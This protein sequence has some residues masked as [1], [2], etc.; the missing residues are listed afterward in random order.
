L[1]A[2]I[3]QAG[4]G[5]VALPAVTGLATALPG[6]TLGPTMKNL[7]RVL[8]FFRPDRARI[9]VSL[10]L[11]LL[12]TTA[13]LL[14]PW[15]L[16]LIVDNILGNKPLPA[17]LRWAQ[18][19]DRTALLALFGLAI[20]V[21]YLGQGALAAS[22][23]YTSIKIGLRGLVRVRNAVFRWLEHLSLRFH[24]SRAQGDLIYR[25]SWDTYAFQTLFQQGVFTF[26][27]SSLALLLM[28]T[29]MWRLNPPLAGL[30]LLMVPVLV[31]SMKILG[32]GMNRRSLA[33]HQA[34]S[35]VTSAI[36]QTIAALP[37]IQSYTRESLEEERFAKRVQEAFNK[38]VAQHGWEVLYALVIAAGFGV[39]A[40][41]LTWLGAR[42]VLAGRLTL[43]E[44]LVF[45]GYLTQ[46][47]EPLNQLSHVGATVS[48]A[49][50]GT[51]RVL[52]L[53]DTPQEVADGPN[54]R[55]VLKE[56]VSL[57]N[58]PLPANGPEPLRVRGEI[59]FDA[60]SF[61]YTPGQLVLNNVSFT[62][63]PGE[64]IALI[65]PSGAGK[66]T[67]LQLLPRF[68]D[69]T[70]GAVR[71]D[72]AALPEIRLQDLRAQV[73]LVPQEPILLLASIAENIAYG[74][75]DAS[76]SE[77]EEAARAAN[78]EG[79]IRRLP[80]QFDTV[81]GEGAARLSAGEKQRINIAR[82]LLKNAPILVLD[83]PTSALDADSEELVVNSLD[84]LMEKRTGLLVAHRLSTV[85]QV[86]RVVVLDAGQVVEM[87]TPD[88][89]LRAGG[90][91]GRLARA[92]GQLR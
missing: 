27:S 85:R 10:V 29:V 37:L 32:G 46:L 26:V 8:Q 2:A 20:V 64:S 19:W 40:A 49:R 75:P 33:A 17:F 35:Q 41:G 15:P 84:R 61:G 68:Y 81:V 76:R 13:G 73:A 4:T 3:E 71:L 52:E 53:L 65:G 36:Q 87:G 80:Q 55:P 43:G 22:Q 28:L 51:E 6:D 1:T 7:L 30:A 9:L 47:Y 16:A 90:Y 45:L 58:T 63:A 50:A 67:L 92:G 25:V 57:S 66:T 14:K 31:L 5:S 89:L 11:L 77:I 44:L 12:S 72:G 23:N 39:T 59:V 88:E 69:P 79:F 42:E 34:D 91:Y 74:K 78:A 70:Q 86:D 21:L 24:L 82:A 38:R 56:G 48:D 83:E 54:P 62:I 60:V 18:G